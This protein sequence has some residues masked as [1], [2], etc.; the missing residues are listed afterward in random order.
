MYK[1]RDKD[2]AAGGHWLVC[3]CDYVPVGH[4]GCEL[5]VGGGGGDLEGVDTGVKVLNGELILCKL[6]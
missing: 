5:S 1:Q 2:T 3:W 4:M 6:R